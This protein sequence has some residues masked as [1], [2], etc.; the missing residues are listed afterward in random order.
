MPSNDVPDSYQCRTSSGTMTKRLSPFRPSAAPAAL[1]DGRRLA[2]NEDW[3]RGRRDHAVPALDPRVLLEGTDVRWRPAGIRRRRNRPADGC[4]LLH[5]VRR[6]LLRGLRNLRRVHARPAWSGPTTD[7]HRRWRRHP[8]TCERLHADPKR[9]RGR[10]RRGEPFQGVRH[11]HVQR[12][13][14]PRAR[15]DLEQAS[16][17]TPELRCGP[18]D[19]CLPPL[20][21]EYGEGLCA[22]RRGEPPGRPAKPDRGL[23]VAR[24]RRTGRR[25]PRPVGTP[26]TARRGADRG[27]VRRPRHRLRRGGP[28]DGG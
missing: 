18:G 17:R 1:S 26:P 16:R 20:E 28:E 3:H 7:A 12:H 21:R 11:P 19:G 13:R 27:R 14:G 25:V 8:R 24:H 10:R 23:R 15:P 22:D 6:G 9:A 4:G 2:F 5:H